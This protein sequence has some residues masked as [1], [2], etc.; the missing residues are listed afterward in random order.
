MRR[1]FC[2]SV[3]V[4]LL[5]CSERDP[6]TRDDA[7]EEDPQAP[8]DAGEDEDG[9]AQAEPA[10]RDAAEP[11]PSDA[12]AVDPGERLDA[13][14]SADAAEPGASESDVGQDAAASGAADAGEV[15][16]IDEQ[17]AQLIL[18]EA[19]AAGSITE[20][21]TEPGSFSTLIDATAGGLTT[22]QSFVYA[23]FTDSGLEKLPI[24]DEAA[25]ASSSWHI[26]ARRYVLR[27]NSGVGGPGT[28]RAAR[29]EPGTT[30]EGLLAV[31]EGLV[32]RTEQYYTE[33]CEFVPDTSGVGAPSTALSSFWSYPGCVKMTNN[34]FVLALPEQHHVKLQVVSYY[35]PDNH[36]RC[37][38]TA[39]IM[40]PSGAGALR[41]R[42]AFL[43]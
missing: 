14:E 23:R 25:F 4:V 36:Q 8:E 24:G 9:D 5:S 43:D 30:F 27:V 26:A 42:W 38:D 31:P 6:V 3:L 34:V 28:V 40:V 22:T 1:A 21:G 12:G 11:A 32:Y 17:I 29:T 20:E 19:P 18:F 13:S 15:A 7:G 2:L 37:Q 33:S 16:C 35:P 39:M 10:D 41:I